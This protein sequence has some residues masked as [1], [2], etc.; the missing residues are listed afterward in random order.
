MLALNPGVWGAVL[1]A[2]PT[3][4]TL[5]SCCLW[6]FP[7]PLKSV[8]TNC[9]TVPKLTLKIPSSSHLILST[10]FPLFMFMQ[11]W[12][13]L[14]CKQEKYNQKPDWN[15]KISSK[16]Q[17][18]F[19]YRGVCASLSGFALC[20]AGLFAHL[21]RIFGLDQWTNTYA[22]WV[23]GW[24][25]SSGGLLVSVSPIPL[26]VLDHTSQSSIEFFKLWKEVSGD[27]SAVGLLTLESGFWACKQGWESCCDAMCKDSTS[28]LVVEAWEDTKVVS[29]F[30][31]Q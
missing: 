20:S 14:K 7:A 11:Y 4:V 5:T 8:N 12:I 1:E 10:P 30:V 13:F 31:V 3:F 21:W 6:I 22:P 28:S 9:K 17:E 19:S 16:L 29:S 25:E 23:K 18:C 15:W 2:P 26:P 27:K 24:V